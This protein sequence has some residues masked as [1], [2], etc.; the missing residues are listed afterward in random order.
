MD[1]IEKRGGS[2]PGAGRK[3]GYKKPEGTRKNRTLKAYD[4]E[5][6][7]I[8]EFAAII[9]KSPEAAKKLIAMMANIPDM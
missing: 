2:R 8:K 6:V 9:K 7:Y 3:V 1:K 4:D 5:W